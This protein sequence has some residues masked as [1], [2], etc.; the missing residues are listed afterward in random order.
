[1]CHFDVSQ[2]AVPVSRH[3]TPV[4]STSRGQTLVFTQP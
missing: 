1:M 4:H 3:R 2:A